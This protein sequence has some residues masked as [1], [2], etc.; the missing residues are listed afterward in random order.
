[1]YV[2]LCVCVCVCVRLCECVC[3]FVYAHVRNFG[4]AK[5]AL[6]PVATWCDSL[7]SSKFSHLRKHPR[8]YIKFIYHIYTENIRHT[9]SA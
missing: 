9:Y 7:G 8:T 1:M 2:R 6:K 5:S 4:R 3:V